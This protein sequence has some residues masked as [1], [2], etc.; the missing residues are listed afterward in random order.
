METLQFSIDIAAPREIVWETTIG[1]ESYNKWT[2][3]FEP[4]SF[5]RGAWTKGSKILFLMRDKDGKESGMSS[6]I[7]ESRRP[8]FL[9]IRHLGM[10]EN[11]VEDLTSEAVKAWAPGY[12]NYT[13][14]ETDGGTRFVVDIDVTHEHKEMFEKIW[15][16]ALRKL[17][18]LAEARAA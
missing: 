10:V 16:E 8:E 13:L 7:A 1:E 12:E 14:E 9:S 6:E 2:Q 17:Q 18:A 3:P 5:Y 11:G 4:T 15:P